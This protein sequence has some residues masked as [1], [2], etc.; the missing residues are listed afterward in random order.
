MKLEFMQETTKYDDIIHLPHPVSKTRPQMPIADRAAQFSPFAALTGHEA[1]IKETARLTKQRIELSEDEKRILNEKMLMLT[2]NI[3]Q[4]AKISITYFKED[5]RKE[6]GSY[7]CAEG[8]V[9]KID[10]YKR[11]VMMSD[12]LQI[13]MEDIFD[14]DGELFG[15][16]D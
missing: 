4:H 9:K 12:G 15:L 3:K 16:M 11:S 14:I 8:C 2:E 5:E 6:G 7:L 13:P 1:A 10:E